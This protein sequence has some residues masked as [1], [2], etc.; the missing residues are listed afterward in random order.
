MTQTARFVSA[1]EAVEELARGRFVVV[2]DGACDADVM[3][4]A[5]HASAGAINFLAAHARGV[6]YLGLTA[7]RCLE[8]D[9]TPMSGRSEPNWKRA[10]TVTIDARDGISTGISA[11]DR[12]RAVEVAID[13]AS[14]ADDLVR[15]GHI[16]PLRAEPG[17]MLT[18]IGR[19]EAFV[20]LPRMAGLVPAGVASSVI[21]E[22]G[23]VATVADLVEWCERHG[24]AMVTIGAA[25]GAAARRLPWLRPAPA[26]TLSTPFGRLDARV[27]AEPRGGREHVA[28]VGALPAAGPARLSV[29]GECTLGHALRDGGCPRREA[30]EAALGA[31]A[32]GTGIV[33]H[34]GLPGLCCTEP[35]VAPAGAPVSERP[36]AVVAR[37]LGELGVGEV[38]ISHGPH[39]L[40]AHLARCGIAV[41]SGDPRQDGGHG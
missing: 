33:V 7:E 38:E 28:V 41:A 20:E 26:R 39:G 13:P 3:I 12:A 23:A 8:L 19:T 37:V 4:A 24:I 16:V 5:E 35:A 1:G 11:A 15:P 9:L 2:A 40:D 22:E 29:F 27:F 6:I 34:L 18:R 32:A 31:A 14:R 10:F 30:F 36:W 25:A 17:G 21:T